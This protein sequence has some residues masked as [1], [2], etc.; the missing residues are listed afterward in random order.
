MTTT[1]QLSAGPL[2]ALALLLTVMLAFFASTSGHS[3]WYAERS[4]LATLVVF[5]GFVS[6]MLLFAA[7]G[8]ADGFPA[9]AGPG[10]PWLLGLV[11]FFLFLVYALGTGTVS[12]LRIAAAAAF[13]FAPLLLLSWT[14]G[15][16]PGCWQDFGTIGGI[17]AAVKFGPSH[18][19]WP[20]PGG[21]LAYIFTVVAAV[22]LAIAG[23]LLLRRVKNV[24]YDIGWGGGWTIYILGPLTLFA[25]VA[26]PLGLQIHF[27]AWAPRLSEWKSFLPLSIGILFFTAWP[28]EFLFRGLLQNLLSRANG[29]TSGWFA[30]SI[31]FG[32]SHI[33]NLHFPNWRYVLLASIAGLFYGWTWRKTGSI[34]ASALLHAGVD[35]L[36][37]FLFRTV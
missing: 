20:Y 7:R 13:F 8:I 31:V 1:R 27:I 25:C 5:A 16:A 26:V 22:N 29:E 33:S 23:F 24:G 34:F 17:W 6:A 37:H 21:R 15:A 32:F 12:L 11:L 3:Y 10:A 28:E 19:L 35:I 2:L 9:V 14:R 30:A 36:W 18:W 4:F